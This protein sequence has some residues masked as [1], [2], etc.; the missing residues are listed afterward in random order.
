MPFS[1]R[2]F[3]AEGLEHC[4]HDHS[5]DYHGARDYVVEVVLIEDDPASGEPRLGEKE[6]RQ[7]QVVEPCAPG[8]RGGDQIRVLE[9]EGRVHVAHGE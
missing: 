6:D 3:P 7:L 5:A 1:G 2:G 8:C 4:E 9:Q